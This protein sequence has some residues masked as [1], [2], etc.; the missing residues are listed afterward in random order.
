MLSETDPARVRGLLVLGENNRYVTGH[1][2]FQVE[3]QAPV[4]VMAV[5]I[6]RIAGEMKGLV[7]SVKKK[8]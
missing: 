1:S 7:E 4:I 6:V 8:S 3:K 2:R 5:G